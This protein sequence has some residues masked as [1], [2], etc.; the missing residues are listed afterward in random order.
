VRRGNQ[1]FARAVTYRVWRNVMGVGLVEQ[2]DGMRA[3]TP[4]SKEALLE[5]LADYLVDQNYDLKSLM[6]RILQ[7]EVY[8]RSSL[9]LAENRADRRHYSRYFPRRLMAEVLLD[10]V[11]QVTD[12]PTEFNKI[13]FPGADIRDT[14][15]YS[16]GTR[17]IQLYDSAVQSY[18][19][20]TFGRNQRRIT[21]ECERSDEPSMVQ[22]LHINNG[23]T[24]NG[25]LQADG[26]QLDRWMEQFADDHGGLLNEVFLTTLARYPTASERHAM[27]QLP[28]ATPA[29]RP[30]GDPQHLPVANLGRLWVEVRITPARS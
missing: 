12:V 3:S 14:G 4:A 26:N 1:S 7:S 23:S 15:F 11:S 18:F 20:Q 28:D 29:A 2:V 16:K 19:L 17:A 10:A 9:P 13:A 6:R 30:R 22:V 8:Q 21:C 27:P 5:A 24:I 25:K